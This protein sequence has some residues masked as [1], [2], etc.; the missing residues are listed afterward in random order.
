MS[1]RTTRRGDELSRIPG[2]LR[3]DHGEDRTYLRGRADGFRGQT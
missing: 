3:S 2:P 1:V